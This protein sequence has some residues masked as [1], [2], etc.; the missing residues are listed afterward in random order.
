MASPNM[1]MRDP[2]ALPDPARASLPPGDDWCIYPMYDFAH[3]LS[4]AIE[5]ITH[6]LCT[7][8]FENNRDIYDWVLENTSVDRPPPEQTE[9]ARLN[10]SYT[11]LSKRKL[12]ELVEGGTSTAGTT[13]H[14]DALGPARRGYTPASI[15]AFCDTIGVAKANSVVDVAQLEHAV[16]D[17][18]TGARHACWRFSSRSR[19]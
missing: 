4:D 14:A 3:C 2:T 12:L 18:S 13:P 16:R 15:R 9:F 1:K 5:G 7:L 19:W 8:E 6:S 17:D 11:V 10:L